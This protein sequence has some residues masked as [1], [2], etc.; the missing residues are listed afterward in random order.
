MDQTKNQNQTVS[1]APRGEKKTL[2]RHFKE[3]MYR[4][5]DFLHCFISLTIVIAILITLFSI[6]EQL[7]RLT[8]VESKSL[9]TFLEYVINVIIAVELIH[10]L[11]HQSLDTIVEI[12]SLAITR[13]LILERM[14]TYELFIGVAAIALLFVIRKFLFI[15]AK[16]REKHSASE[17]IIGEEVPDQAEDQTISS[18]L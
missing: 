12:L 10:V 4:L 16:D 8:D 11:L 3:N 6:P 17:Y 9:I 2:H 13:E 7:A 14:H 18:H 5:M 15:S 1:K